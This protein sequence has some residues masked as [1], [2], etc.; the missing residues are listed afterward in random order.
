MF[1]SSSRGV[2]ILLNNNFEYK[3]EKIN[4]DV[5]GNYIILDINIEGKKFTLINLYGPNDDKPK[6]Y[7]EL[8]QKYKSL[9]NDNIIMCGDWNLV[10]NPDLDTNNYL[11]INN[12]RARNEVLDIIIEEDG[13][14]DTYRIFHEEKR[15]YTWSRR[16][17]V[18]KQASLDFFLTSFEC[19]LYVYATYIIPGYRTDHSVVTLELTLN[20]NERGRGYL[21]FNNSLLKDHTYIQIVKDTISDVKQTY[22]T[23]NNDYLDN[24]Q[25]EY[26]INSQL[27]LEPLLLMIRGNTIKYSSFKKK[28][29][30][31]QQEIQLEQEIK[32]IEDE[33][34][35]NFINMSDEILDNLE[36]K[37]TMLYDIQKDKIEGMMLRSRSRYE[38]LGE[39]PTQ[40]FFNLEKRNYTSKAIHKL[41]NEDG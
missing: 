23:N 36:T 15:E 10:I 16:N 26:S 5:N 28:K 7:K 37:K 27:F 4:S 41:V 18:R 17:P 31:Q 19:F 9:N 30:Q 2:L 3:V 38:D 13:F 12:P 1:N 24:Q 29:Q 39:K 22:A 20:E 35:A 8:R 32:I 33:V 11:H 34:N 14:L 6:F 21:K 25:S 40:Y